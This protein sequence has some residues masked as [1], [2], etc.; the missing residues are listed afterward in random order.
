MLLLRFLIIFINFII[1]KY[2]SVFFRFLGKKIFS[3]WLLW[4]IWRVWWFH[5]LRY[6][7]RLSW[8]YGWREGWQN[9]FRNKN[10]FYFTPMLSE[11][12]R[13]SLSVCLIFLRRFYSYELSKWHQQNRSEHFL[14]EEIDS[15]SLQIWI[16]WSK[17]GRHL[18]SRKGNYFQFFRKFVFLERHIRTLIWNIPRIFFNLLFEWE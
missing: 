13:Y 12:L 11:G 5:R 7:F 14:L 18:F 3:V 16:L 9:N 2:N 8:N 4:S 6:R 10:K 15:I 17:L 1:W